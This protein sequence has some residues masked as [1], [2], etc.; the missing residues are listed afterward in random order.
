MRITLAYLMRRFLFVVL[1]LAGVT[2]DQLAYAQSQSC[3]QLSRTLTSLDRN[4]D[5][6]NLDNNTIE[7]RRVAA[8]VQDAESIFVRGGCQATLNQGGRLNRECRI[9]ARRI[10]QGR[11]AYNKL[12]ANIQTGQAVMEQ[13]EQALQQIARFGCGAGIRSSANLDVITRDNRA[14]AGNLF[15]RLFGREGE[16]VDDGFGYDYGYS[17][18]ST[19]RTVCVRACDGYYW[20][21]SFSTVG[22]FL[23]EDSA[24]CQ[25]QCPGADVELY[26]YHNPGEDAD[27]MVNLNGQPY[28]SL[29][30]AFRYR[31]EYDKSCSCKQQINYGAIVLS[32]SADGSA[33]RATV[34]FENASFPLP[35]RDPRR[36]HEIITAEVIRVPLPRPR[37]LQDGEAAPA[38][39]VSAPLAQTTQRSVTIG[40]R[41]VRLVGPDTPYGQS[42]AKGS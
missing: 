37:P 2:V 26:Y 29:G 42:K 20:P 19:L 16:I 9:V 33:T 22:D 3:N 25:S 10:T 6:R 11:A 4:R 17:G 39:P 28:R 23:G 14:A 38:Q 24:Q 31:R 32:A 21:V 12:A 27:D 34:E 41:K 18:M 35:V 7:A 30:N 5:F 13:R 1:A 36:P 15:D 8:D 40:D